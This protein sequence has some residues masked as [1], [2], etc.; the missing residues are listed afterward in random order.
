MIM[1]SPCQKHVLS[2]FLLA[3]KQVVVKTTTF[4][5][6]VC[7]FFASWI[8]YAYSMPHFYSFQFLY[9]KSIKQCQAEFSSKTAAG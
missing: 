4:C 1:L 8:K 7:S 5:Q 9:F 6:T 3:L 2:G